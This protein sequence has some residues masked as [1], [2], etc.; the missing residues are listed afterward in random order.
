[1]I[2][3]LLSL[4]LVALCAAKLSVYSPMSL[5]KEL[6]DKDV[7]FKIQQISFWMS[8]LMV[9]CVGIYSDVHR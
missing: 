4:L 8:S 9:N 3:L 1:M 7:S 5:R 6:G 2:K